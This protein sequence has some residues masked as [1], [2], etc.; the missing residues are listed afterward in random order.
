MPIYLGVN[1]IFVWKYTSRTVFS[2]LLFSTLWICIVLIILFLCKKLVKTEPVARRFTLLLLAICFA[3]IAAI[4]I[5][6]DPLSV[7]VDR[8][9]ATTY[10]LDGLFS[11]TYPYGIH[12]HVCE[13]NFPSPFPLWHYL[14]IPFW[15]I[16]D[17]GIGLF[18][19]LAMFL[20]AVKLYTRSWLSTFTALML[21]GLSPA[22]WWEVFVRSDGLSNSILVFSVILWMNYR[23]IS[24]QTKWLST[25]IIC[26][27]VTVTRLSA[28]IPMA[29]YL[30]YSF[31]QIS[32]RYKLLSLLVIATIIIAFFAPYI[33]WDTT[34]W[35]FFNRNPL[36]SQT[37]TGSPVI[38]MLM[39]ALALFMVWFS[40]QSF[41]RF[42]VSAAWFMFLFFLVSIIS[43]HLRY[44]LNESWTTDADFDI[45]YLTL[46]FP[47]VLFSLSTQHKLQCL[48][49]D[50]PKSQ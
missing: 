35:I 46:S 21:L 17:V 11:H 20:T 44:S 24:F 39:I 31:I 12:T 34:N 19:F 5:K 30:F 27:L 45:S 18:F 26:G 23:H 40:H 28:I 16:G 33:L 38:M 37:S 42:I 48:H 41:R 47:Y 9:S 10:F 8:W 6:V 7:N 22:Y 43:V 32:I 36:L 3:A 50:N 1:A 4:L 15:L 49:S 13:T 14:N 29:L 2:P 25:A